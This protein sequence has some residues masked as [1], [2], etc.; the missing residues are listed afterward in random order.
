[1]PKFQTSITTLPCLLHMI[2]HVSHENATFHTISLTSVNSR[3]YSQVP[4][5]LSKRKR[6]TIPSLPPVTR[7][8]SL[9]CKAVTELSCEARRCTTS[10]FPGERVNVITRPS[11]PP[12]MRTSPMSWS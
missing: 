11:D 9:A 12:E 2:A 4:E 6:R 5:S 7:K 10:Y 3:T 8:R 1:M